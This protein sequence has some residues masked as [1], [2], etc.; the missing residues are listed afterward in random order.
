MLTKVLGGRYELITRFV[1]KL[2]WGRGY[3]NDTRVGQQVV[4]R[5]LPL[6]LLVL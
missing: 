5:S 3:L 6:Q 4:L 1:I 2:N